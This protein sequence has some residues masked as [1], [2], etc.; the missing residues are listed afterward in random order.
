M[1]SWLENKNTSAINLRNEYQIKDEG[2]ANGLRRELLK[3]PCICT[4]CK[5]LLLSSTAMNGKHGAI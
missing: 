3:Q 1:K 4:F 5:D 2:R